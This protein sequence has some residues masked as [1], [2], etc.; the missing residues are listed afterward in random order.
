ML[1]THICIYVY[2]YIYTYIYIYIHMRVGEESR[3]SCGEMSV[4]WAS[5]E[6]C[7]KAL[8]HAGYVYIYI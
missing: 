6:D 3:R 5:A 2:I 7:G 4:L 8:S 1:Y